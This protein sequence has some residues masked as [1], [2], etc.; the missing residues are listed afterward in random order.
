MDILKRSGR[1]MDAAW[2]MAISQGL[3]A[4]GK[5]GTGIR[6]VVNAGGAKS[7]AHRGTVGAL[8]GA[9]AIGGVVGKAR[10]AAKA[11]KYSVDSARGKNGIIAKYPIGGTLAATKRNVKIASTLGGLKGRVSGGWKAAK[12]ADK[13]GARIGPNGKGIQYKK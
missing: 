12:A 6:K 4:S 13:A 3:K 10:G 8:K 5:V 11:L 1:K 9:T 2:K 7:I